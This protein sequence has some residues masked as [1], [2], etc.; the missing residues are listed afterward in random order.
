MLCRSRPSRPSRPFR[1]SRERERAGQ[2]KEADH[3]ASNPFSAVVLCVAAALIAATVPTPTTRAQQ[4]PQGCGP[5]DRLADWMWKN[6]REVPSWEGIAADGSR[7]VLY[8]A[9]DATWTIV[10]I[11]DGVACG[12]ADGSAWSIPAEPAIPP[13][14]ET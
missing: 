6:Y 8:L 11:A 10:R 1:P 9:I 5:E 13:G 3:A 2:T 12:K 14:P 4:Y 7:L